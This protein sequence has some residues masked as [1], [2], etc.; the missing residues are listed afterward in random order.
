MVI[1]EWCPTASIK[2]VQHPFHQ[3]LVGGSRKNEAT[4]SGYFSNP[5]VSALSSLRALTLATTVG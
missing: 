1:A 4:V 3:K 5:V 2:A